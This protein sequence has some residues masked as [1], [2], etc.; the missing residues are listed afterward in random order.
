MWGAL[1]FALSMCCEGSVKLGKELVVV[2]GEG[3]GGTG[4]GGL[5]GLGGG[6]EG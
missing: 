1:L 5:G 3:E 6:E 2:T 4:L